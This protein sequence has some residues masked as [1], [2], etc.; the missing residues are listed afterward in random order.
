[1]AVAAAAG[2]TF[3]AMSPSGAVSAAVAEDA[4][5]TIESADVT[6]QVFTLRVEEQ[7]QPMQ[8]SVD[9]NTLYTLD[10][11]TAEAEKAL[12]I[13]NEAKVSYDEASTVASRVDATSPE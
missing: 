1:M 7:P 11:A 12:Q 3:I 8:F 10:G 13:G 9:E 4:S 5:G 2:T 6:S